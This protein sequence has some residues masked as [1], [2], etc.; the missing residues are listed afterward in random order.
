MCARATEEGG[1]PHRAMCGRRRRLELLVHGARRWRVVGNGR[2]GS[3]MAR[4]RRATV[5][6]DSRGC[7][8]AV[9]EVNWR[10]GVS[11]AE[12]ARNRARA[13]EQWR[14]SVLVWVSRGMG[15]ERPGCA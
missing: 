13:E 9:D 3:E 11:G 4:A 7:E 1:E 14:R 5:E 6:E 2:R 12:I 8:E 15:E 10:L